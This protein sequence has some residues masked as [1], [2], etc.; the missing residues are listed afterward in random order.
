M[1]E[2]WGHARICGVAFGLVVFLTHL[3]WLDL[4]YYWDELGQFVPAA[5]DLFHR[6]L[7]VPRSTVPNIHPP[8]L[9][10]WLAGVWSVFGYS[11]TATR[12]AMLALASFSALL[13]FLL[14]MRLIP[15]WGE[16]LGQAPPSPRF[17]ALFAVLLLIVS[18]LFYTQAMLAELDLPAMLFTVW[19]LLLFLDDR[20]VAAA[21]VSI[22]LVLVKETG[23]VVPAVFAAWLL[24]ERK[25]REAAWFVLPAVALGGWLVVLWMRTGNAFG[26]TGFAQFNLL[27]PLHPV[28]L[29]L[30]LLRRA[31][32]LVL[33]NG[34]WIGWLGIAAAWR[35]GLFRSRPWR[36]AGTL[37]MAHVLAVTVCGGATLERYLMPVLPLLYIAM[38]AAFSSFSSGWARAGQAALPGALLFSLFWNPPYPYPFENNLAVAD[39]VRLQQSGAAY[40][41]HHYPDQI[42]VTAWPLSG[43]LR[44]PGLGY[45]GRRLRVKEIDGFGAGHI[46]ALAPDS[47]RLFVLYSREWEPGVDLRRIPFA[48]G[49]ARRFYGYAPPVPPEEVARRFGL[50]EVARWD[51]RG[52]WI[53]VLARE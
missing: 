16:N 11:I 38:A 15:R 18:P 6:G 20:Y 36:I 32:Y 53:A 28:R 47:V 33:D 46:A 23:L 10:V 50:K 5:L 14:G 49:L 7:W 21:L 24:F 29:T 52:Q 45:V 8:G 34:H 37:A 4:P 2:S 3:P 43:A 35:T 30:A 9:M 39:F 13:T 19:A 1:K 44:R 42:A 22:P 26:N 25:R 41:E 17:C 12:M 51:R 40:V 31:Q 48:I 27:Y